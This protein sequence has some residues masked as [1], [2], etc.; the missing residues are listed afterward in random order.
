MKNLTYWIFA[1]ALW[2]FVCYSLNAGLVPSVGGSLL[3]VIYLAWQLDDKDKTI[4]K[5]K[6]KR[7]NIDKGGRKK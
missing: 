2:I 3:F 4:R 5:F 6:H 7:R 1:S